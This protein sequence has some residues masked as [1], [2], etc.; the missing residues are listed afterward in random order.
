[1]KL[2]LTVLRRKRGIILFVLAFMLP[3]FFVVALSIDTFSKRKKAT[4]DL[5][6]SNLWLSGK[7]ALDQFEIYF[8]EKEKQWLNADY[9]NHIL[10]NDS[11]RKINPNAEFFLIDRNFRI[12]YPKVGKDNDLNLLAYN[13]KW[14]PKYREYMS[15]AQSAELTSRNYM[16]AIKY[17]KTGLSSAKT[18]Q[19]RAL[20]FEGMARSYLAGQNYRQAIRYYQLL[21][22]NFDQTENLSGHPYGISAPLQLYRIE[23]RIDKEVFGLD[24]MSKTYQKMING[25][26]LISSAKYFFFKSEYESILNI[27][28][29]L[30]DFR[31]ERILNFNDFLVDCMVP[32]LEK[33]SRFS[34][35]NN[36]VDPK[37][38]CIS[39]ENG[40][41]LICYK[42]MVISDTDE[43]FFGGIRWSLDTIIN[44]MIPSVLS[45]LS[46][47]TELEFI[48][49]NDENINLLTGEFISMPDES[50]SLSFNNIPFPWTLV[51]IQPGYEKLKSDFKIELIIYGLLIIIIL[52]LMFFGVVVLLRDINRETESMLLKTEFVHNVSHELKTPLSLI[53]LYGETL[54][55][56]DNLSNE[57]RKD[58]LTI[59]TKESE[60]L[61]HM[62]NNILNFSKIEMGRKEFDLRPGNLSE[63]VKN[64]L[65]SY[66]YHFVK[67]GFTIEEEINED[68]Q[69]VAFDADAVEG[70]LVNLFSNVIKFSRNTKKMVLT[71]KKI[72]GK[73]CLSVADRGIGI[74]SDE[75]RNIFNRFYRVKNTTDFDTRGSGLGLTL[76][77]H[78]VDAHGWEIKVDS[79]PEKGSVFSIFIPLI[80]EKEEVI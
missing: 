80:I 32:L 63:L 44:H 41:Y 42:N 57:D 30:N 10:L 1:M 40:Q 43:S 79:T 51:A 53:R 54:L 5:L 73:L 48:L 47:D 31:Y 16:D 20:T 12:V 52:T 50:I 28:T 61:S 25:H 66:R 74:P 67:K 68:I 37:R 75:L 14:D 11:L 19:Q 49:M 45:G 9:F 29:K 69:D 3:L 59:I 60:R 13:K 26:W 62:I 23:N 4:Q 78:V 77:K 2:F 72:P 34:E 58:G 7:S 21:K 70:I 24:S 56:K 38:S 55:L 8:L 18:E 64:T 65:N 17:Y 27:K 39:T 35:F 33:R 6:E 71:L 46:E 36:P 22:N 15:K 76:V